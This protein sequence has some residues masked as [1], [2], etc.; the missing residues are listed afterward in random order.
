MSKILILESNK[1]IAH[2]L[3]K[4]CS[5]MGHEAIIKNQAANIESLLETENI[6]LVVSEL[7][8]LGVNIFELLNVIKEIKPRI[9]II[10]ITKEY[11]AERQL[12][13]KGV[14]VDCVIQKPMSAERLTLE[15]TKLIGS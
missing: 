9:K 10:I 4:L 1:N 6:E 12:K 7:H 3:E 13:K 2:L 8:V 15:I 14:H 11:H 5:R